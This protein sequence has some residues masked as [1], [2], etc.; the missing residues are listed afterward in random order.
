MGLPKLDRF[1]ERRT[2][3]DVLTKFIFEVTLGHEM[4][5]DNVP[6]MVDPAWGNVRLPKDPEGNLP[7]T[8]DFATYIFGT[9][10]SSITTIRSMPLLSDWSELL[11]HWVDEYK[12]K[13]WNDNQRAELK[14]QIKK[15]HFSYKSDLVVLSHDLVKE[16]QNI[17]QNRW[18]PPLNPATQ[19]CSIAV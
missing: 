19:A 12:I 9:V 10:I 13:E 3:V 8:V 2:L 15:I 1:F 14:K 7:L 4:A 17:P 16:S 18:A 5:A 11:I 6:Y